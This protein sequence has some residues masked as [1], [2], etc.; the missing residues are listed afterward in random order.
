MKRELLSKAFGDIDESFVCEAY[1]PVL[2]DASGSSERIVHMNRKR[3]ISIALAAAI[4]LSLGVSAYAFWIAPRSTGTHNMPKTSEYNSLSSLPKIEKDVGFPATVP[5]RFSNGYAFA[6]LRVDG[7]AVFGENNEVLKEYYT[8]LARYTRSEAS[9][10]KLELSPLLEYEGKHDAPVPSEQRVVGG[11]T[12]DLFLDHY[13]VVPEG[14][15]KTEDD[16]M[17]EAAGHYYI[18]FGSDEIE[19]HELA[20]AEFILG[21]IVYVLMDASADEDSASNLYQMTAEIIEAAVKRDA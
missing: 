3:I 2:E 14:Y 10:L 1:R 7:Q 18:S 4:I 6:S 21:D 16:L 9:D 5:E 20:F 13:K 8:V 17:K 19:E 11:V 12:V 15:E